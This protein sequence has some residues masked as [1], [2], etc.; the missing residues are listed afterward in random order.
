MKIKDNAK[1]DAALMGLAQDVS[2]S[3]KSRLKSVYKI[4]NLNKKQAFFTQLA[5][6]ERWAKLSCLDASLFTESCAKPIDIIDA[7]KSQEAS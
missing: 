4:M 7:E 2:L 5:T 1:R 3:G 6:N